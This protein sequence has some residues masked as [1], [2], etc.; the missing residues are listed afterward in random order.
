MKHILV[1]AH[2]TLVGEH[3]LTEVR[4]R[5]DAGSCHFHLVVPV[6]HPRDHA[7]SDG[8][9]ESLARDRL[10]EGLEAFR[11]AGAEVDGEIGDVDPVTA[12]EMAERSARLAGRPFDEILL[13]TLPIGPS[14]WLGL[15]S[16]TRARDRVTVPVTHLVA[17]DVPA[18]D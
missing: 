17:R 8:E 16:V 7:W 4:T 13:S 10:A 11:S 15:D 6:R 12:I 18:A 9:V 5:M 14:S 3:L 2:R 1:V